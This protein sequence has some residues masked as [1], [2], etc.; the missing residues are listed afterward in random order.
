MRE[1]NLE[2]RDICYQQ[3]DFKREKKKKQK[4]K[5]NQPYTNIWYLI[6]TFNG[7]SF[8]IYSRV[9]LFMNSVLF[10]LMKDF[11]VLQIY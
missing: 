8:I 4:E 11:L 2:G 10:L 7:M 5:E 9:Y 3:K 1:Y 6:Y